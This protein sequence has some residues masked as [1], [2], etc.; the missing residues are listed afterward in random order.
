MSKHVIETELLQSA[1]NVIEEAI[2]PTIQLKALDALRYKIKS[3]AIPY[4]EPKI[5][6]EPE[7]D[8]SCK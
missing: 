1:I 4:E 7:K 6:D 8:E 3:L 5:E 2:H